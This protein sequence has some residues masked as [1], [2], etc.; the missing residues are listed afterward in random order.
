VNDHVVRAGDGL[1]LLDALD[2]DDLPGDLARLADLGLDE[3]VCDT[4]STD[5]LEACRRDGR[6]G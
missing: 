4:T 1:G 2:V 3:D 6:R 5:L